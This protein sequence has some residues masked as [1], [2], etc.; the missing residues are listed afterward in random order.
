[1]HYQGCGTHHWRW[2]I[3]E[4][5]SLPAL[6]SLQSSSQRF[7]SWWS[8]PLRVASKSA[9]PPSPIAPVS[10]HGPVPM[11]PCSE[12]G[13]GSPK[14]ASLQL[15]SLSS[16][17]HWSPFSIW[18]LRC[19]PGHVY[20]QY[21]TLYCF[22]VSRELTQID[23]KLPSNML[24]I[25]SLSHQLQWPFLFLLLLIMAAGICSFLCGQNRSIANEVIWITILLK[26]SSKVV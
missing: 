10:C 16:P 21:T 2:N 24:L 22:I 15:T 3:S 13:G 11:S 14:H 12:L 18:S 25:S 8:S 26:E 19:R 9:A 7:P 5:C 1:M 4:D 20:I 23:V 6:S 17:S